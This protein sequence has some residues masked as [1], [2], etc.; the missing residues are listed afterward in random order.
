MPESDFMRGF[1]VA[2]YEFKDD[3]KPG[4]LFALYRLIFLGSRH[5]LFEAFSMSVLPKA[6]VYQDSISAEC[7]VSS[8]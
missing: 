2:A 4:G 5:D 1:R 7:Y 3:P 8:L 6:H